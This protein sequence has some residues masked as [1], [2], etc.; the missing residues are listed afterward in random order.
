MKAIR[1]RTEYLV[2]PL[3]IDVQHPRLM[4]NCEG[5]VKQSAYQIVTDNWDSGKVETSSMHAFYPKEL[6][7]RE[8]VNW[9]IRL[10]DENGVAGEWSESFFEMGISSWE[11]KWITGDYKVNRNDRYPVDLFRK[12]FKVESPVEKAR[13]YITACGT[14]EARIGGEKTGN[15]Y[16][17][18][19]HTDY[20]RRVQY[21]TI[22]V[23][24]LLKTG[25]NE[26]T[27]QLADGWYRGSCGAWG[28]KNQYG[29]RTKILA[30]LEVTYKDGIKNVI[31][32][33][34]SWDWCN[35][36]TIR[37]ADNKDGEVVEAFRVPLFRGKAKVT[38]HSVRP[39]AS[40]NVPV[41]EHER[42]KPTLITTPARKKV[43]DFGQNIAGIISFNL[44]AK[45][46]QRVLLKF[47]EML[48]SDGEFTQE[49]IQLKKKNGYTTPLQQVEYFC[50]D[51]V[52]E[53]K[54][55]FA[56]FGFRYALVETEAEFKA[57]DFTAIAVYSDME[58][59]GFFESSDELLNNLFEA[60]VW[61]AKG[62]HLDI[63]TDC[64][65]RERHGWTG[66]AQI[67]FETAAYM[68][69]FAAFSNKYLHDVYDLQS[70]NGKLPQIAPAGGVDKY[71]NAMNGSVG[72][73]DVGI[74]IPYR[75]WKMFGDE[76]MIREFYDRMARYARFMEK[77]CGKSSKIFGEKIKLSEEN[78]K[79]LV[80][81][82]QSYGEWAEPEDV[83]AF[84]WQDFVAPHPEV[85]T[86]Y[87]A[88]V[89]GLMAEIAD[90]LGHGS[91]A[92]EF[93]SYSE[94]CRNAYQELVSG[95]KY[96]LDSDRQAQLVRPLALGLLND[97]QKEYARKRLIKA[98][99]NYGWRLGT[100]FL[101][102]PLILFVLAEYDIDSA[103]KLLENKEIPGWLSMPKNGATTIW[104]NWS[105]PFN[106]QGAGLGS[107][108]HYSKGAVCEWLFKSMCGI[109][110]DGENRFV[111]SPRPGGSFTFAKASYNSVFGK[112]E[113]EW[114]KKDGKVAYN[115]VIPANCEAKIILP[116]GTELTAGPGEH[117]FE[118]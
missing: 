51:G 48:D 13:L 49:N 39:T 114:E 80:N 26:I 11:A 82:G 14:Y 113:S 40:N 23:T 4:W 35:D 64:P 30:Q 76:S 12:E 88:Y 73:S 57:E 16:M 112:V 91:D 31:V 24:G 108:N 29:I 65:T 103:Y 105:G 95:G 53:Y 74:L 87:T 99:E 25:K 43:L 102:S 27:L 69:D 106:T 61:S 34:D 52:N 33:D 6:A 55:T 3:G 100:G 79:Y 36:G 46:G 44:N 110:V 71:M 42:F 37:F 45:A 116:G 8:R 90:E 89:L 107:L 68:F 111:I 62:N 1:L 63:P 19:G 58:Q 115:V 66:D 83:C 72:W 56:V 18:P 28:L 96:T 10:F 17:A 109:N 38:K 86:A 5:G 20:R 101:S 84:K 7:D 77:R 50:K 67:F 60:T 117:F 59:T 9:K 93:R 47:G 118:E 94:G 70:G 22:D 75:F 32:T 21:Q 104:E 78:A 15:F 41:T 97:K 98:L 54:T 2:N 92:E 85:S 81:A